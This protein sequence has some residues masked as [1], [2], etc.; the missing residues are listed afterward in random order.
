MKVHQVPKCTERCQCC[1]KTVLCH[2]GV[3]T[4]GL[5]RFETVSSVVK[6][7]DTSDTI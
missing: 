5:K 7:P 6:E 2:K 3:S 1:M 4:N